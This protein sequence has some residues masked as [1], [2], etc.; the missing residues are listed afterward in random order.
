MLRVLPLLPPIVGAALILSSLL[1]AA[2]TA[3][4]N[5]CRTGASEAMK[6]AMDYRKAVREV[7]VACTRQNRDC[8]AAQGAAMDALEAL[9]AAHEDLLTLC[10]NTLPPLPTPGGGSAGLVINEVDYD[11]LGADTAE[12]VE[13][14]NRSTSPQSL[15]GLALVFF[16]GAITPATEY[17]RVPLHGTLA[18]GGYAVIATAGLTGIP[19]GTLT[20]AF[21]L[22]VNNIQNGG[23]DGIGLIETASGVIRDFVAYEG[24]IT[25]VLIEGL[26]TVTVP[27]AN[28]T[29]IGD[30]DGISGSLI[31]YPNG[32][33]TD[34]SVVDWR[35]TRVPTPGT[36][37]IA[38]TP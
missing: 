38:V 3:A 5:P 2:A 26:G 30:P 24:T 17:L 20:F 32:S 21:P 12:F 33:D 29:P 13:I 14:F 36:P 9:L 11:R 7:S 31:R 1:P 23:P 15:D 8:P 19:P 37:N 28:S 10:T 22:A 34:D 4:P 6:A 27:A 35:F 16:N 18:A 25:H